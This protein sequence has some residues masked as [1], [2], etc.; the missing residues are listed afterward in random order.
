MVAAFT[1]K[2]NQ[3]EIVKMAKQVLA[4]GG[5]APKVQVSRAVR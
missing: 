2:G 5:F 1:Q 3:P 4:A